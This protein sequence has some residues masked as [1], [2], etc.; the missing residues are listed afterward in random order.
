MNQRLSQNSKPLTTQYPL[1][2]EDELSDDIVSESSDE[3]EYLL[4][5]SLEVDQNGPYV[6]ETVMGHEVSFLVGIEAT[7]APVRTAEF[8]NV[9]LSGITVQVV[10]VANQLL[11]NL[12]TESIP[13]KIGTFEGMHKFVVCDSSPVCLL[14]RDLLSKFKCLITCTN[15]G[16]AIQTNRDDEESCMPAGCNLI[17]EEFPL[18]TPFRAFT[19][20]APP[21]DL[22]NTVILKVW[23]L[24]GKDIGL[25]KGVEPV[26]LTVKPNAVF[27]KTP[28]YHMAPD[29]IE[30][31]TPVIEDFERSAEQIM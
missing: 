22:Q 14:V 19:V 26:K 2:N 5:A 8:H 31:F 11:T 21:S 15:E 28:Q 10:G 13:V 9:P 23:D 27:P 30:G 29:V 18:I 12:I 1:R 3:E 6:N 20:L 25:T 16:I 4:A 17:N 7:R 24:S